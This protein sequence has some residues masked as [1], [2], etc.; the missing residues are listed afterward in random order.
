MPPVCEHTCALLSATLYRKALLVVS[1]CFSIN[2]E[3]VPTKIASRK[4]I[5]FKINPPYI[6]ERARTFARGGISGNLKMPYFTKLQWKHS[7]VTW[8]IYE[9]RQWLPIA[10]C[11]SRE[12]RPE[13]VGQLRKNRVLREFWMYSSAPEIPHI[14]P[15]FF[16]F[17]SISNNKG[18]HPPPR[19]RGITEYKRRK[20]VFSFITSLG[21]KVGE[22]AIMFYWRFRNTGCIL[23]K[24]TSFEAG[25]KVIWPSDKFPNKKPKML[26]WTHEVFWKVP[27]MEKC[28]L[29]HSHP[30]VTTI[31]INLLTMVHR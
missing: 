20:H 19:F 17:S 25:F 28:R 29:Q 15:P 1:R 24:P 18:E 2:L 6:T 5:S 14:C 22:F 13:R 7:Q 8:Y 16:F 23:W 4:H 12:K 27:S 9:R 3:S 21:G 31:I 26:I 30:L 11:S 10:W